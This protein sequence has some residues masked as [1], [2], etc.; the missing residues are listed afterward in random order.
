MCVS[1]SLRRTLFPP[2]R[3]RREAKGGKSRCCWAILFFCS[4]SG[5]WRRYLTHRLTWCRRLFICKWASPS[6]FG[7]FL[8]IFF[9]GGKKAPHTSGLIRDYMRAR[10]IVGPRADEN[11]CGGDGCTSSD[12]G[13]RWMLFLWTA[14]LDFNEKQSTQ[15]RKKKHG[16]SVCEAEEKCF[17]TPKRRR[18]GW[19]APRC[20]N[21]RQRDRKG[22]WSI[23]ELFPKKGAESEKRSRSSAHSG[24]VR[25]DSA[26]SMTPA[27]KVR[28]EVFQLK[29]KKGKNVE[30]TYRLWTFRGPDISGD[31]STGIGCGWRG[32][33][34]SS[35]V[36][37]TGSWRR[38]SAT[39]G[40]ILCIL[41]TWSPHN[42]R[43]NSCPH[44]LC[45]GWSRFALRKFQ[46]K[47]PE[48]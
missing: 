28:V 45:T 46:W 8:M 30:M 4:P 5:C 34:R 39:A 15:R 47:K 27:I 33:R 1:H 16:P 48:N 36:A 37:G 14:W 2:E 19:M 25:I 7:Y 44:T 40:R 13:C 20:L 26:V 12:C 42:G 23:F 29:K 35:F 11:R 9:V 22:R 24:P 10:V 43:P 3:E 31:G 32:R 21:W 41:R 6:P 38:S 17:M 18:N